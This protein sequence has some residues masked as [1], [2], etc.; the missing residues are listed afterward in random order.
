ML[1]GPAAHEGHILPLIGARAR[2]R[3][4]DP[5]VGF[6]KD[7][8]GATRTL[9]WSEI[10]G[11]AWRARQA[12][13]AR[14][15]RPGDRVVLAMPTGE[16]YLSALLGSMWGG[17]LPSTLCT[18]S[19]PATSAGA[20]SEWRAM[21]EC[22]APSVV[23]GDNVPASLDVPVLS[24][25]ELERFD[26]GTT[27]VRRYDELRELAYVQFTSGS[28]GR[29]RGL[30]LG[31]SGI[32]ANLAAVARCGPIEEDDRVV[33]WLP[34]Y[35]DMGLFGTLL[36]A[37]HVG[38]RGVYMDSSLFARNPFLWLRLLH[39]N[40][41][42]IAVAPPSA[43]MR[44]LELIRRRP[45]SLDLSALRKILCGSEPIAPL[46]VESFR[47]VLVPRGVPETALKPVYG[48]AEATLAVTFPPRDCPPRM[49]RVCRDAFDTLGRAEP[50]LP[51]DDDVHVWVSVG[52]PLPGVSLRIVDDDGATAP[53]RRVG[54][55]L[56]RS[57]SLM[58]AI[59]ENQTLSPRSGD[60]LDTGDLGYVADGDLFVTGRRKDV[61]I[62][63]G[64][65]HSPD[66]LEQIACLT[67]GVRRAAAF[68]VFEESTLTEK[69]VIVVEARPKELST[70]ADRDRLRLAVRGQLQDAGYAVDEIGLV[71]GGELPRTTSGKIRRRHCR[72][73]YLDRRLG[74]S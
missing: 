27:P 56:V 54:T 72:E 50:A 3:G 24:P 23:V 5:A 31:W 48:L 62:R 64:R 47:E 63:Y 21:V 17:L 33:S 41:A 18:L 61:I 26:P 38:C 53:A 43:L 13:R 8:S 57:P 28:T 35:H 37:L 67:D 19:G 59:V 60:W 69:I 58:S 49:D 4:D 9:T 11:G 1:D 29:P 15:L 73:L 30:A 46:L 20:L 16:T 71:S 70:A 6:V 39:D 36:T 45:T 22:F 74:A 65:N 7:G 66:R 42:T 25:A 12:L 34:M 14:G 32:R 51:A 68:G 10:E 52:E 55:V 2:S 40:R 44:C